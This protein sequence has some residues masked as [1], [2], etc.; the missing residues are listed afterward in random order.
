[1]ETKTCIKCGEEKKISNFYFR[2][3]TGSYRNN[4]TQCSKNRSKNWYTINKDTEEY[5]K[6]SADYASKTKEKR[7]KYYKE[8]RTLNLDKVKKNGDKWRLN[9]IDKV[10]ISRKKYKD[11]NREKL[12][13][14]GKEYYK[15]N[16]D[17]CYQRTKKIIYHKYATDP[18]FKLKHNLRKRINN[19]I[20][21]QGYSKLSKS[22]ETLGCDFNTFKSYI[23]NKFERW[24][25]WENYGG[26]PTDFNQNWDIDHIIPV[27]SATN[28]DE[29]IKLNHYTNLQPLCSYYNRY[30]KSDKIK[31]NE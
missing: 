10:K 25:T 12:S 24:M 29:I 3:D 18:L 27:S 19:S 31:N 15:N 28:E 17:A 30:I 1:M 20:K 4:C 6:K 11:S 2:K 23:E 5:K 26:V 7:S 9:N 22:F 16:K 8:W 13:E 21:R 14:Q